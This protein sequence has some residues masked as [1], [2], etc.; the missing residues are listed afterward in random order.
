MEG[1]KPIFWHQGLFL[2]P[3]HLQLADL[4]ARFLQ[5]PV[6]ELGLPHFWGA[7]D[8]EIAKS[9]LANR[10]FEI[11]RARL[12]F[13]DGTYV[14]FPGNA[15]LSSR[16]FEGA[17][18]EGDKP[19]TI[20]LGVKK[21][22]QQEKNVTVVKT[23]DDVAGVSTRF[24]TTADPE[25]VR[26]I[27]GDGPD[28]QVK[29][30]NYMLKIFWEGEW[31]HLDDYETMPIARL[32]R[33]GEA[34]K[35][36][37]KFIPPC[38]AVSGSDVL[39]R[40]VKE[41]RDEIAG[42]TRQLEEYKS[43]REMQKAEFDASY[44]VYLLALRSLNRYAPLFFHYSEARQVHPWLVY[45]AL[46]QLIGELS[47]FSERYNMLGETADGGPM[48]PPYDHDDLGK[49]LLAASA[50]ITQLLNEITIGPEFLVRL[51]LQGGYYT[52]D[53]PRNFF[54]ARNR[55]YL[56]LRTEADSDAALRSFLAEAKLGT[57]DTLP[58]LISRALPGVELIHM[59]VAPQGLPRRSYSLYF[60]IEQLSD[61]WEFVEK[62]GNVAL[63]WSGVPDD[64]VAE[65]VV[66]RR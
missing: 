31:R 64:L 41:I 20:Y 23:Y 52:A 48:L 9:S 49:C 24:V 8:L 43:P 2:Q 51:E 37:E 29:S 65:I 7:G 16:S 38:F 66:L 55:F 56:V 62:Q 15:I 44:M 33:D 30:L 25:E 34:I 11:A 5:K 32:E 39:L 13:R 12:V 17:W 21:L 26:D 22:N 61:Q 60:R 35:L 14:E 50:L 46:R 58:V 53:L 6:L 4:H 40:M 27:Y 63:Y 47:S 54:G 42:R 28:A 10:V 57:R 1:K 36:S 3:Q 45:G 19:F 59:P 18:T